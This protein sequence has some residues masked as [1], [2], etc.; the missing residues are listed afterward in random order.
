[1]V[2]G[3]GVEPVIALCIKDYVEDV[4]LTGN[5]RRRT[6]LMSGYIYI[7]CSDVNDRTAH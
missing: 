3:G 2:A 7:S 5:S 1:M 6:H 4:L